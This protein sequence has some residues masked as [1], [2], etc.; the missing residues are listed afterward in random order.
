MRF[1]YVMD[2]M[3]AWCYGFQPELEQFLNMHPHIKMDWVV[4]GLAPDTNQ[5]MAQSLRETIAS[6]WYQIE[7]RTQV[8]F[9][10]DFW[11]SNTPYRS[12]YQACRAI[13]AAESLSE[14]SAQ[15][16]AKAIQSAYYQQAKNPSLGHTL[17]ACAEAIGL[18]TQAFLDRLASNQTESEF[19]RHLGVAQQLQV[20]GF[21]ALFFINSENRAFPLALGFCQAAE[22]AQRFGQIQ[23]IE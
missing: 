8:T 7:D 1:L 14:N 11:S 6:Y 13:I 4:G 21:P 20:S 5:P 19:Q 2:P 18:D 22:L 17:A 3:C 23:D 12:T 10:H 9:N 16:M 15:S